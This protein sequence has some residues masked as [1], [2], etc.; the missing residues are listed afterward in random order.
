MKRTYTF[1]E[2][3]VMEALLA[4]HELEGDGLCN[5]ENSSITVVVHDNMTAKDGGKIISSVTIKVEN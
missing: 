4:H 1:E 2:S 5:A 3:E